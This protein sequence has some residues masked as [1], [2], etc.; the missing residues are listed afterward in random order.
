MGTYTSKWSHAAIRILTDE[1]DYSGLPEQSHGWEYTCYPDAK[2]HIPHDAPEPLGNA[3]RTTS[4]VD[5]NLYHDMV[6]GRSVTGTIHFLN[7]TPI[8]WFSKLQ[9]TVETAT[10]GS[11]YVASRIC[12]EQIID[13]RLTLRYLGV[14]IKS[15]SVMFGDNESVVLT[16]STPHG[17]LHKRHVALSFHRVR[18]AI[19]AGVTAYYHV[20]GADNPADI[21]SKHWDLPSV[22]KSLKAILLWPKDT[23]LLEQGEDVPKSEAS[24]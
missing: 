5:A 3:V 19:A 18:D 14:P 21:L 2:E 16:G 24:S 6:S 10:F 13:L 20:S 15:T 7:Q 8:D 23:A 11:E 12:T 1:P 17:K 9:A 22:W 4:Y